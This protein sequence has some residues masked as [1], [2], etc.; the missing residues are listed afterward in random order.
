MF[1]IRK[2]QLQAEQRKAVMMRSTSFQERCLGVE[3][4]ARGGC[5]RRG[6]MEGGVR[7]KGRGISRGR[8][9]QGPTRDVKAGGGSINRRT[10]VLQVDVSL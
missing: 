2:V 9:S 3:V 1:V 10:D 5:S 8:R 4:E 7:Q 6:S